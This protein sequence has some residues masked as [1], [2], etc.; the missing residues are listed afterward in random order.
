MIFTV[1]AIIRVAVFI[2]TTPLDGQ[3]KKIKPN[4]KHQEFDYVENIKKSYDLT[5]KPEDETAIPIKSIYVYPVRGIK[6]I[7][8]QE[9]EVTPFGIK[10][11]R[12]WVIIGCK[13]MKPIANNN[14]HITSFLRQIRSKEDPNEIKLIL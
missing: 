10:G 1:I 5:L 9:I 4:A 12:N 6:G 7:K 14:N 11:D 2:H 3:N 13:K 8:V